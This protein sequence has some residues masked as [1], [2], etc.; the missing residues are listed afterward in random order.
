MLE[1]FKQF[2]SLISKI[3][4]LMD[5]DLFL[6]VQSVFVYNIA[7]N[8]FGDESR[9]VKFDIGDLSNMIIWIF[10][11]Y[12]SKMLVEMRMAMA[13]FERRPQ[14]DL[15]AKRLVKVAQQAARG[16]RGGEGG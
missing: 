11:D 13:G 3:E 1:K 9:F 15:K 12:L 4:M 16:G 6:F 14:S 2:V 8:Y 7:Q 5:W 10:V